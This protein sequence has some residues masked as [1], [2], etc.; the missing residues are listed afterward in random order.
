MNERT[1]NAETVTVSHLYSIIIRKT[2]AHIFDHKRNEEIIKR[3]MNS[4]NNNLQN[5]TEETENIT[6]D[7]KWI[8]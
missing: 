5:S 8:I 3:T 6:T 4:T 2:A 1:L 7:S